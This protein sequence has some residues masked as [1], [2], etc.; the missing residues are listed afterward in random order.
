MSRTYRDLTPRQRAVVA[1]RSFERAYDR[2]AEQELLRRHR[3]RGGQG[4]PDPREFWKPV[5]R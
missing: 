3:L 1:Q 2:A 5:T 4:N